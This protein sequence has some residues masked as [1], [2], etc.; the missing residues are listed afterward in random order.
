MTKTCSNRN[1]GFSYGFLSVAGVRGL[2]EEISFIAIR[3]PCLVKSYLRCLHRAATRAT[4]SC[5]SLIGQSGEVYLRIARH[6]DVAQRVVDDHAA[7]ALRA[8]A[9]PLC[10]G[11]QRSSIAQLPS[12]GSVSGRSVPRGRSHS[13][14]PRCRQRLDVASRIENLN[15]RR[16]VMWLRKC[17]A[18]TERSSCLGRSRPHRFPPTLPSVTVWPICVV[19]TGWIRR[20]VGAGPCLNDCF[21]VHLR[22]QNLLPNDIVIE[23]D[24]GCINK[25]QNASTRQHMG[26]TQR[27]RPRSR[28]AARK[29]PYADSDSAHRLPP[30]MPQTTG[31]GQRRNHRTRRHRATDNRNLVQSRH[32]PGIAANIKIPSWR[33]RGWS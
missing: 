4:R 22:T 20:E 25:T 7:G 17:M 21:H 13:G 3:E 26:S 6:C 14:R 23:I 30:S 19:H 5:T 12:G 18:K 2:S 16:H 9:K 29:G 24:P 32:S 15:Q 33:G 28:T 10:P 11:G 27:H 8:S 1:E 31:V